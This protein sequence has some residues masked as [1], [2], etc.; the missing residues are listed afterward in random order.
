M[1]GSHEGIKLLHMTTAYYIESNTYL[2]I[3][4]FV[5][6]MHAQVGYKQSPILYFTLYCITHLQ[7]YI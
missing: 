7:I 6:V 1:S 2:F 4:T 5:Y 3:C